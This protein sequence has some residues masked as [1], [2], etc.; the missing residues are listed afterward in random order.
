M[1]KIG[2]WISAIIAS[3][4]IVGPLITLFYGIP[5]ILEITNDVEI[6]SDTFPVVIISIL[7]VLIPFCLGLTIAYM[8]WKR[9]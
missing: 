1:K 8:L 6:N 7:A 2:Y 5:S 3:F 4:L 9:R